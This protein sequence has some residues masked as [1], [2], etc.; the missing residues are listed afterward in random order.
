MFHRLLLAAALAMGG[1][2]NA[3]AHEARSAHYHDGELQMAQGLVCDK[4]DQAAHILQVWTRDGFAASKEVFQKYK[5]DKSASKEGACIFFKGWWILITQI[6]VESPVVSTRDENLI[7][8]VVEIQSR[9]GKSFY[10][11]LWQNIPGQKA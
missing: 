1:A 11:V 10:A 7:G 9:G 6:L 3:D 8:L 2:G 4:Q 5:N